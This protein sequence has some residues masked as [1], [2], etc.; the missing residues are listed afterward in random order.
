M[1][2]SGTA[3]STTPDPTGRARPGAAGAMVTTLADSRLLAPL[4]VVAL[5]VVGGVIRLL[6][7]HDSL[8]ADELSTYWVVS[9]RSF[10]GV[11]STVHTDAEITPPLFFALS[12]LATRIDFTAEMLRLPSYIAGVVTIPLIYLIGARTVGRW[13]ATVAAALTALAPFMIYYST[14][15]RGYALMIALALLS[16]LAML[17]AIDGRRARW[18]VLYAASSCGAMYSH[19]TA[20]FFLAAQFAWVL[21]AHPQARRAVVLANLG[22]VIGFAPWITGLIADLNSP[23]TKLLGLLAPFTFASVRVSLEHWSIGYPYQFVGLGSVPGPVGLALIG[24]GVVLGIIAV[25]ARGSVR[26][27]FQRAFADRG[28]ILILALAL[29]APLGEA[30]V[31]LVGDDVFGTR[32]LAVSWPAAALLA[33]AIL[34]AGREPLRIAAACLAIA[35]LGVGAALMLKSENQRT[36]YRAAAAFIERSSTSRDVVIDASVLSPGPI[37]GL[38]AALEQ[39]RRVFRAGVPQERDHPFGVFDQVL[40]VPEVVH[41]A[42][43][44]ADGGR[45]FVVSLPGGERVPGRVFTYAQL[46]TAIAAQLQG[47]HYQPVETQNYPGIIPVA[48]HTYEAER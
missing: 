28:L 33:A 17:I 39:P 20:V 34:R 38:D 24:A 30:A 31:S 32:N 29:A 11:I 48:V 37:S 4:L 7:L 10:G 23:T 21:W 26:P 42:L 44:E 8:F 9:G 12:W 18:W 15:A 6:V 41:D 22:A 14:E 16:T 2:G 46:T 25:A 47:A 36:D 5:T 13:A 40:P 3:E 27:L 35:G 43:A 45:V 1:T 19:Y